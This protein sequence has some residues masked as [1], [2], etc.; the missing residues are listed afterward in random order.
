MVRFGGVAAR[1]AGF[2]EISGVNDESTGAAAG[3]GVNPAEVGGVA[4]VCSAA[5]CR[6]L[7][8]SE[9]RYVPPSGPTQ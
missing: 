9:H 3:V 6:L 4:V 7:D 8:E 5:C 1:A 2:D